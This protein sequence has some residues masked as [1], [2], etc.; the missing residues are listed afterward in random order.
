MIPQIF[1][2][3]RGPITATV[4]EVGRNPKVESRSDLVFV[5]IVT[6]SETCHIYKMVLLTIKVAARN[7]SGV[8]NS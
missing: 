5:E 4:H 1:T 2:R 8:S 6:E 7:A 3:T